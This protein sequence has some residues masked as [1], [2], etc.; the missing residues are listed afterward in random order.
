MDLDELNKMAARRARP[1]AV[2]TTTVRVRTRRHCL[3]KPVFTCCDSCITSN[4]YHDA[5][6]PSV[7]PVGRLEGRAV[8]EARGSAE[9]ARHLGPGQR[10]RRS[11]EE[12][13]CL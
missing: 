12:Q 9:A 4:L 2:G 10:R 7:R 1:P 11:G 8:Q 3:A 13:D 6:R 5:V